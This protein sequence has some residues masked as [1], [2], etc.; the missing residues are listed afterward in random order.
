MVALIVGS[1]LFF[2]IYCVAAYF[3]QDYVSKQTNDEKI[4]SEWRWY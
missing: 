1:V 4:K 3:I 2:I